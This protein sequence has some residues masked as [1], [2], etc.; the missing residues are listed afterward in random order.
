MVNVFDTTRFAVQYEQ[1]NLDL[2]NIYDQ[3]ANTTLDLMSIVDGSR[4]LDLG[5]GTGIS[6]SKLFDTNKKI[7]VVGVD[8]S[9]A[10]LEIAKLKFGLKDNFD[11]YARIIRDEHPYPHFIKDYC[12]IKDLEAHL[13]EEIQGHQ[14]FR[15]GVT[16]HQL[17]ASQISD[18][19][20]TQ[21]DYVLASQI[22][23]WFRKKDTSPDQPNLE[24]ERAVLQQ[25]RNSLKM[26]GL[27]G[28][29]TSGSDFRFE[30]DTMN[31]THLL[32]HPFFRAFMESINSQLGQEQPKSR[33]YTFD[34][35]E[36]ERI[37][38]ENGFK[39]EST[40]QKL[41]WYDNPLVI[42]EICFVGGQM[43]IFQNQGIESPI[44]ERERVL[45]EAV[46]FALS[47][48]SPDER[49]VIETGIH[50]VVRKI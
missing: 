26:N 33:E 21:F 39:I 46:N 7:S 38:S 16:F 27:L 5:C 18:V 15:G 13:R 41:I 24:Y 35:K 11:F 4:I 9:E 14:R 37:M 12:E 40:D 50:Y 25:V 44:E 20:D 22:I 2:G 48:S 29:N 23:H 42:A 43:Q 17:D 6:T 32:E 45:R 3:F 8:Q 19:V 31:A 49:P 30:G 10:F 34:H 36:I 1:I 28:F 47:K